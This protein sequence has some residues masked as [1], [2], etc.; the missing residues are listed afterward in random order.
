MNNRIVLA[1]PPWHYKSEGIWRFGVRAG[2]R[3]PFTIPH[4]PG[5]Y[6]PFPFMLASASSL[7]HK[8]GH[9]VSL[10]DA[11]T[12]RMTYRQ[13]YVTLGRLRPD[14]VILETSFPSFRNDL[15]IARRVRRFC[16]NVAL[17]GTAATVRADKIVAEG[18]AALK[19]SFEY[20]VLDYLESFEVRA[21]DGKMPDLDAIG[22]PYRDGRIVWNYG[23]R[24]HNFP[25]QYSMQ[26]S[27][28]CPFKCTF[29]QYPNIL[30]DHQVTYRSLGSI[31]EELRFCRNTFGTEG[32]GIY[33]DDDTFNLLPDRTLE[34]GRLID[35]FGFK[36]AAMCK[37]DLLSLDEWGELARSGL[38]SVFFGFETC[39]QDLLK[40]VIKKTFDVE[41]ARETAKFLRSSGVNVHLS[42]L[43]GFP[44]QTDED[45]IE[46][47]RLCH[48]LE[49]ESTQLAHVVA[50]EGTPLYDVFKEQGGELVEDGYASKL[51][52]RTRELFWS[53][54]RRLQSED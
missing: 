11:I 16:K 35:S 32:Y 38:V 45:I 34:I 5:G 39:D 28:G 36:W 4:D 52:E 54:F 23:E 43:V 25:R 19:G 18:F 33:F 7:L 51:R 2:S 48:D 29:C 42:F 13:F 27:R 17:C 30:Y 12:S 49:I 10:I 8:D 40:N 46:M 47:A 6:K 50:V 3:W 53:E 24:C 37:A 22:I 1:N 9:R 21:Y 26:A 44:G 14:A 41:K 31:E 20:A 15:T